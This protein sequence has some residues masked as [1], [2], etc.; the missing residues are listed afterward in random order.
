MKRI[1]QLQ[2]LSRDHHQALVLAN[3]CN[4]AATTADP[5]ICHQQWLTVRNKFVAE[6]LPHFRIEEQTIIKPLIRLQNSTLLDQLLHEHGLMQACVFDNASSEIERLKL[7]GK[8]LSDHVRFEERQLFPY[9]EQHLTN[10]ELA[11][12]AAVSATGSNTP[13]E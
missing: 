13:N 11:Q 3:R 8:L 4:K 6:L 2:Q 12:I 5:E 9:L 10:E 7:F 1:D